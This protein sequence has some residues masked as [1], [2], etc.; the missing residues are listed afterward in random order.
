[1]DNARAL[2]RFA[3][4]NKI[5]IEDGVAEESRIKNI[6]MGGMCI[7]TPQHLTHD[8]VYQIKIGAGGHSGKVTPSVMVAWSSLRKTVQEADEIT[9]VYEVG[10]KF[11]NLSDKDKFSLHKLITKLIH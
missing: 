9:P 11:I 5:W 7:E 2:K 1:M 8:G 10:L 3:V 4:N 6:S